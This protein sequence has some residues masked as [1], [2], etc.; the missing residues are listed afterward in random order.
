[1]DEQQKKRCGYCGEMN[2]AGEKRCRYCGDLLE[3]KPPRSGQGCLFAA[4]RTRF[5]A[6]SS[7]VALLLFL[8]GG[9]LSWLFS[10]TFLIFEAVD[11]RLYYAWG[12]G[13]LFTFNLLSL[14]LSGWLFT[15]LLKRAPWAYRSTIALTIILLLQIFLPIPGGGYAT[16]TTGVFSYDC[17]TW[18]HAFTALATLGFA[19]QTPVRRAFR[20]PASAVGRRVPLPAI[21]FWV[22]FLT[23]ATA[24]VEVLNHHYATP[25]WVRD[26]QVAL[27]AGSPDAASDYLTYQ[28]TVDKMTPQQE[29]T[30]RAVSSPWY[31]LVL[32]YTLRFLFLLAIASLLLFVRKVRKP[33][34]VAERTEPHEPS[35][36]PVQA[37][38]APLDIDL[39]ADRILKALLYRLFLLSTLLLCGWVMVQILFEIFSYRLGAHLAQSDV[40]RGLSHVSAMVNQET[41]GLELWMTKRNHPVLFCWVKDDSLV[42]GYRNYIR[43]RTDY[44]KKN[45]WKILTGEA[46]EKR[47]GE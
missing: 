30:P 31:S 17:L 2:D 19:F 36:H 33:G 28:Q 27:E 11:V 23:L 34:P 46:L 37:P 29:K 44:G 41:V 40:E 4:L 10:L 35:P 8:G 32:R 16:V 9:A 21:F 7:S 18:L 1:M 3:P 39:L 45:F 43:Y 42:R 38:G 12:A 22:T 14:L 13:T 6:S 15:A 47:D 26:C 5:A 24:S 20:N 25:E